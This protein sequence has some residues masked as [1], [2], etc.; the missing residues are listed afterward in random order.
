MKV[1][2]PNHL[3]KA[4][5]RPVMDVVTNAD[6]LRFGIVMNNALVMCNLDKKALQ[7]WLLI[8]QH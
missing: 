3:L 1:L 2:P 6:L 4:C 7:Q 5:E 8:Q